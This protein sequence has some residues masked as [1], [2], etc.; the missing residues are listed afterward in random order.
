MQ[1]STLPSRNDLMGTKI[2]VVDDDDLVLSSVEKLL[3]RFGYSITSF[4]RGDEAIQAVEQEQFDLA[5]LDM[6]MPGVNGIDVLRAIRKHEEQSNQAKLPVIVLTGYS[7]DEVPMRVL[8][9]GADAYLQKP[10][11]IHDLLV[12]VRN[13]IRSKES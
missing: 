4:G 12:A 10:F 7:D 2:M 13:H 8:E 11:E 5:I 9:L 1:V 3:T 6:R